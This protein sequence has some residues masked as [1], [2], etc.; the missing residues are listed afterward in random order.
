MNLTWHIVKKDLRA[1]KWP[2]L[3]WTM[4]I[5]A[6]LLVGVTLL[7]AAGTES[8]E[9]FAR[10][11]GMA[12]VLAAFECVSFV[13]AAAL[14]QE[15]LLVGT[16][17]FW[18][19]RPISG[20]RLLRAKVLLLGSIFLMLPLLLTL[21]WWLGCGYGLREI[22][23]ASLE[24]VAI[25]ATCLLLGVLWAVV[26]DGFA[27]FLMWTLVTLFAIP[28][29][30][31]TLSYYLTRG[32]SGPSGDLVT[33]RVI[34]GIAIAVLGILVVVVHQ[35][36]TQRTWRSI[37][38]ISVAAGM[39]VIVGACW[40]WSWNVESRFYARLM[41]QEEGEWQA[42][43]PGLKFAM[44]S[45][46]L[47]LRHTGDKGAD[48]AVKYRVQGLAESQVLLPG[49]TEYAW[50]W[51]DGTTQKGSAWSRSGMMD[52]M[53]ERALGVAMKLAPEGQYT[54]TVTTLGLV[55]SDIAKRLQAETP[56]YTM[57]AR[58]L[59]MRFDSATPVPLQR[60]SRTLHGVM[61]E[62]V[63]AVEKSGEE[64]LVTFI[65]HTPSLLVD[66]HGGM[67]YPGVAS[68]EYFQY[69]LVN[70]THDFVDRGHTAGHLSTQIGTVAITWH[71]QAF[72]ASR[73]A[74]GKRPLLEAINALNDAELKKVNF[75]EQ[76]RFTHEI[77]VDPL[78]VEVVNQ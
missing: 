74:G 33:T 42:E 49:W 48:V 47:G 30:A 14:I 78:T 17:A 24:T 1:F 77:K 16:K 46:K 60:G 12:K 56:G 21:P 8:P 72:R 7:N 37:G 4:L 39:I 34:V 69:L 66:N 10:M 5:V 32:K 27:R 35:Y 20:G 13:L 41:R 61:G 19:T 25:H 67:Y 64:L 70:G 55:S 15:D 51:A 6:K 28:T 23:W 45:A 52:F 75:L 58:L 57:K 76:A 38:L 63:A 68:G 59:L 9:W 29:L 2:L 31:G 44:E 22:A 43:P 36:L 18:R 40:P 65:Q 54:E 50:H 53:S 73:K 62:R 3:L 11:D 26:T 71:T